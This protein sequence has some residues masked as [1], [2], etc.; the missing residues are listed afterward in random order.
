MSSLNTENVQIVE[1]CLVVKLFSIRM[2]IKMTRHHLNT[3]QNFVQYSDESGIQIFRFGVVTVWWILN[4][5]PLLIRYFSE[6]ILCRVFDRIGWG[7]LSVLHR[8]HIQIA[9]TAPPLDGRHHAAEEGKIATM[10][11]LNFQFAVALLQKK[12]SQN[13]T[14][15]ET[16][17][18]WMVLSLLLVSTSHGAGWISF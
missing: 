9:R 17:K 6:G 11:C 13:K 4:I 1:L 15:I 10:C 14:D 12:P 3:E 8:V 18:L 5:Y 7:D 2:V 16:V